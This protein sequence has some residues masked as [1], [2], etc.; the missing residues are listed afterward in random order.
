MRVPILCLLLAVMGFRAAS[1]DKLPLPRF[2]DPA[3][4]AKL[5]AAFPEIEKLFEDYRKQRGAPGLVFGVI[6][7]GELAL[8]KGLGVRDLK[9]HDPVTPDTMFRIASMTKSFT[10]LAILKLRDEGK[11]SLD[12]PASKYIPELARLRL[13]TSD[14]AP[15]RVRTLLTHSAGFPED[16]PWGDQQLGQPDATLTRW[17]EAGIPFSTPPETAYEYSNYGF[18]LLGRIVA[19]AS[20]R[21]YRDY[22]EKEILAPLGM[23][24]TTLEPSAAP[25]QMRATGYRKTGDQ[26]SEEP[27]LPHG[28]FGAMGGLLTS[29]NDLARYVAF[30]LSAWP[31]R[32]GPVRGPVRRS[33]VR[34]M[35]RL[36]RFAVM[37]ADRPNPAAPLRVTGSGYGY[38]LSISRDCR[39][40]H[41]VGHGGG[42]PGFGSYMIW[43]PE[44]GV[45]VIAMANLTYAGPGQV[46]LQALEAMH[47]T[48]ALE[49]RRLPPS[50]ALMEMRN[51]IVQLWR[52]WNDSEAAKL[53]TDN[54]FKDTA[55]AERRKAIEQMKA[56]IGECGAPGEVEPENLLR[57][58]FRMKCQQGSVDATFTLA[59]TM[60][61]KV[62]F[63]RFTSARPLESSMRSTVEAVAR[64]VASPDSNGPDLSRFRP[65][66]EA[67]HASYGACRVGEPVAGNG[68]TEAQVRFECDGGPLNVRLSLDEAGKLRD[69]S[70]SRP[71]D[72]RCVP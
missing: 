56:E 57:G 6:I 16:N 3:R 17:L 72:V 37:A 18:A 43:L 35:H 21:D 68:R 29:A 23:K 24:A 54:L 5:A 9:S 22:L 47:K 69:I 48:G 40:G 46:A 19:K 10:A 53:A 32:D 41:I 63:L 2:T 36:W 60:P 61:L 30:H 7:D 27:P 59:P 51:A 58:K 11:L 42:L 45:G 67:L 1:Q 33:S 31:L 4:R 50:P 64:A 28:S 15:I 44:Y 20:G 25:A 70:F 49:P 8:A 71:A 13:P 62:Q 66:F 65:Q 26:Y 14:S 12:D 34:E 39:F 38:G 55:A 52:N